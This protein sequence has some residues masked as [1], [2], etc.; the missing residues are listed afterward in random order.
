MSLLDLF[1][2]KSKEPVKYIE[3]GSLPSIDLVI[4]KIDELQAAN[5]MHQ[6]F[7]II[8]S[9]IDYNNHQDSADFLKSNLKIWNNDYFLNASY[10]SWEGDY[11]FKERDKSTGKTI[12]SKKPVIINSIYLDY[13]VMIPY[14][15]I[16]KSAEIDEEAPIIKEKHTLLNAVLTFYTPK[17]C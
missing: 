4:N 16:T 14:Q 6:E 15:G 2:K 3:E 8:K 5:L 13:Y 1:K 11:T 7:N 17:H 9:K 10:Q 12:K